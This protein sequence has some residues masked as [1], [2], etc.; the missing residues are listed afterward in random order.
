MSWAGQVPCV[1]CERD[2][3]VQPALLTVGCLSPQHSI[4]SVRCSTLWGFPSPGA[5]RGS[6]PGLGVLTQVG[7]L[8]DLV[9]DQVDSDCLLEMLVIYDS[10]WPWKHRHRLLLGIKLINNSLA[11]IYQHG[12]RELLSSSCGK[13]VWKQQIPSSEDVEEIPVGMGRSEYRQFKG[14]YKRKLKTRATLYLILIPFWT[15]LQDKFFQFS[16]PKTW[17]FI[18]RWHRF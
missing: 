11:M 1:G 3:Q 4:L 15:D 18:F 8:G 13:E 5:Q 9:A 12:G 6:H 14:D 10:S 16:D 2:P 17:L 7:H